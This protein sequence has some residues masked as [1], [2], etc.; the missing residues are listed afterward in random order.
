MINFSFGKKNI[1]ISRI[2]KIKNRTESFKLII[3]QVNF[4][5]FFLKTY[6]KVHI[7]TLYLS[8]FN[9]KKFPKQK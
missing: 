5:R 9:L 3:N 7:D 1:L 6:F 8:Y 4:N 2:I